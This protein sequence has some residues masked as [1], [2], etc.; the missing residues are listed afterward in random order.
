MENTTEFN[1]AL[2]RLDAETSGDLVE[3]SKQ[4]KALGY[5]QSDG[6]RLRKDQLKKRLEKLRA[7]EDAP[8]V[9]PPDHEM[10]VTPETETAPVDPEARDATGATKVPPSKSATKVP[11][12]PAE[13]PDASAPPAEKEQ[14]VK[15]ATKVPALQVPE[16]TG[17]AAGA[18]TLLPTF[19]D[20]ETALL[21][22]FVAEQLITTSESRTYTLPTEL[23]EIK[24]RRD[25]STQRLR[26]RANLLEHAI[27]EAERRWPGANVT[28]V[29]LI[30]F[31]LSWFAG[32]DLDVA[33]PKL[34]D[35]ED[36]SEEK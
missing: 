23:P 18:T 21:K 26:I 7:T 15:A 5:T 25:D 20:Q 27:E 28:N 6:T 35:G 33:L 10:E 17:G 4:L 30:N 11:G 31:L 24:S 13:T 9:P 1:E 32:V 2:L 34:Q 12:P 14:G 19:T 29:R 3:T 16:K 36:S 8:N 22:R